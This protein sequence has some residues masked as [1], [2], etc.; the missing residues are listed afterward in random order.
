MGRAVPEP[1]HNIRNPLGLAADT[2]KTKVKSSER[3]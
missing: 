3:T 2:F 1:T